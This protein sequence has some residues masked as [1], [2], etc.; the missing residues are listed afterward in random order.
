MPPR[1]NWIAAN[2][3]NIK[4]LSK[5]SGQSNPYPTCSTCEAKHESRKKYGKCSIC[6]IPM[7]F[8]SCSE[9]SSLFEEGSHQ[10]S[11]YHCSADI[12]DNK[13]KGLKKDLVEK[14]A[15]ELAINPNAKPKNLLKR[16]NDGGSNEAASLQQLRNFK[17]YYVKK[18]LKYTDLVGHVEEKIMSMQK[19][20]LMKIESDTSKL[21]LMPFVLHLNEREDGSKF[22]GIGSESDP[23]LLQFSTLKLIQHA[24]TIFENQKDIMLHVD[25]THSM[26]TCSKYLPN[27]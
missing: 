1:R 27:I 10:H 2:I 25:S 20:E 12:D 11:N 5:S 14:V 15:Q 9:K 13:Q 8:V 22:V 26:N 4:W 21:E 7:L 17:Y 24:K 23:L 19:E 16:I 3:E 18:H 6:S